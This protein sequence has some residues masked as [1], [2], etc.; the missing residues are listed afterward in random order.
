[1]N[2][3]TCEAYGAPT[4]NFCRRCGTAVQHSARNLRLPVKRSLAQPPA[5]WQQ[6]AP[7][8]ARGAALIVA[9]VAAEWLVRSAARKALSLPFGGTGQS[10]RG[11]ALARRRGD[12]PVTQAIAVSETILVRR[13]F[14]R[15]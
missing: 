8:V 4:D 3:S 10:S 5:I 14:L 1:M 12:Q 11:R 13:L 2:C 6:A 15:R 7:A 9:G